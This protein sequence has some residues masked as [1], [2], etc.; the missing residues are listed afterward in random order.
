MQFFLNQ[1][2]FQKAQFSLN[3]M[4]DYTQR[5]PFLT[6][7]FNFLRESILRGTAQLDITGI[8]YVNIV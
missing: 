5:E 7:I 4:I 6:G 8:T 1:S 2:F 3:A